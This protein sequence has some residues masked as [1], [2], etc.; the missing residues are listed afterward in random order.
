MIVSSAKLGR[1]KLSASPFAFGGAGEVFRASDKD[2]EEYCVKILTKPKSDDFEKISYMVA[3]VPVRLKF[4]WGKLCWPI[5]L[6]YRNK[7]A[8]P[9]G[10]VMPLAIDE[11]LELSYLTNLRWPGAERPPL[12]LKVDRKSPEGLN[13]RMVVAVNLSAAVKHIHELGYVFVDLKPQNIL[14]SPEGEV[15]VVDLDSLQVKAGGRIFRGP[16][17]SP[18]YMPSESYQMNYGVGPAI[19][20]SWD[21]FSLAVI[22]YEVLIGIHPY[23]GTLKPELTGVEGIADSIKKNLYVHGASRSKF[24]VIPPP[25]A[26]LDQLPAALAGLF[27]KAF[28]CARPDDR[29]SASDWGRALFSAA[30]QA[31]AG[32]DPSGKPTSSSASTSDSGESCYGPRGDVCPGFRMGNLRRGVPNFLYVTGSMVYLC[33]ECL[34]SHQGTAKAENCW[35]PWGKS[36]RHEL[37]GRFK[38]GIPNATARG[39]LRVY[40]CPDCIGG[41]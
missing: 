37:G 29:P 6:V 11:S 24:Q 10:Y 1:L 40:L 9:V 13:K 35:G 5:D 14:I 23:T 30:K 3:N 41:R 21:N 18:D 32:L 39:G 19:Q 15:S 17:G 25:H 20:Q 31:G 8:E 34:P 33:P 7:V 27:A 36:C 28:E 4:G 26:A 38:S 16:L 22:I 2:G 12:A